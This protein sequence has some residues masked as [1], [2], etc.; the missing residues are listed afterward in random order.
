MLLDLGSV[1][2]AA[3]YALLM[4]ELEETE[5]G[6]R[7]PMINSNPPLPSSVDNSRIQD[8]EPPVSVS[9]GAGDASISREI[10][11][12]CAFEIDPEWCWCGDRVD[13]HTGYSHNHSPVSMGCQCAA[14]ATENL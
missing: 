9:T 2:Q 4:D 8:A 1:R 10:C 5:K 7:N 13:S 6:L 12:G 11:S 3:E 14:L